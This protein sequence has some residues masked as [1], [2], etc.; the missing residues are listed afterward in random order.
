MILTPAAPAT[1]ADISAVG[2]GGSAFS[3]HKGVHQVHQTFLLCSLFDAWDVY[4]QVGRHKVHCGRWEAEPLH[5]TAAILTAFKT[6]VTLTLTHITFGA[7]SL[8]TS[9]QQGLRFGF[10]NGQVKVKV[11]ALVRQMLCMRHNLCLNL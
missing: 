3:A 7:S 2:G 4:G 9:T 11:T 5:V 8:A 6:P 1:S 10:G